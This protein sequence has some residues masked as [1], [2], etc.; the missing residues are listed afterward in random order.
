MGLILLLLIAVGCYVWEKQGEV[1][2][3]EYEELL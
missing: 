2:N 1:M 3:G